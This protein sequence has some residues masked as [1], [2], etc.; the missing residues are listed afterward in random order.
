MSEDRKRTA[1]YC[2][3][4]CSDGPSDFRDY[5]CPLFGAEAD[6][7]AEKKQE[8]ADERYYNGMVYLEKTRPELNDSERKILFERGNY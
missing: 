7:C 4:V 5:E 2:I 8:K 3:W 6:A 1:S